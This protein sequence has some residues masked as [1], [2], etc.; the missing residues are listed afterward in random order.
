MSKV[1]ELIQEG[2]LDE[3]ADGVIDALMVI[4]N[5]AYSNL[6]LTKENFYKV[7]P[8]VLTILQSGKPYQKTPTEAPGDDI[9]LKPSRAAVTLKL[10]G[11]EDDEEWEPIADIVRTV[12]VG[13]KYTLLPPTVV[14]YNPDRI[15][16]EG[17]MTADGVEEVVTYTKIVE[18][19]PE[20]PEEDEE[21]EEIIPPTPVTHIL[22][23][24]YTSA[25]KDFV[26]PETYLTEVEEG[27][28]YSVT[29]P[30]VEGYTADKLTVAG[31]VGK[32][33]IDVTVTYTKNAEPEEETPLED[34]TETEA[35]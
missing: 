10:V 3:A 20:L 27:T 22:S 2:K 24:T 11:P 28:S 33:D 31:T 23:I 14:G 16:V 1:N 30:V 34:V 25:D 8:N 12:G 35:E 6:G 29:S 17:K 21:E 15:I 13:A 9:T 26:A 19:A 4:L 32:S 18:E 5:S 7:F